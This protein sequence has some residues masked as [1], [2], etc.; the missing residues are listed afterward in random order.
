MSLL[1]RLSKYLSSLGKQT[2]NLLIRQSLKL[3]A[4]KE[5]AGKILCVKSLLRCESRPQNFLLT[6]QASSIIFLLWQTTSEQMLLV[7][8]FILL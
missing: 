6:L 2:Y 8:L 3:N 1:R 5:D 4:L 7:S